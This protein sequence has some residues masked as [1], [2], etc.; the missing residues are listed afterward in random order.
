MWCIAEGVEETG[1]DECELQGRK[2]A[3]EEFDEFEGRWRWEEKRVDT[4]NDAVGTKLQRLVRVQMGVTRFN[5]D[6]RY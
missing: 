5:G 6:V 2:G 3:G 4:V 1:L